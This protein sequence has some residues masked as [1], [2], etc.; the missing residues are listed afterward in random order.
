MLCNWV[1]VFGDDPQYAFPCHG[2]LKPEQAE[3]RAAEA[4][5]DEAEG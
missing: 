3:N 1:K 2:Q 5:S 4:R